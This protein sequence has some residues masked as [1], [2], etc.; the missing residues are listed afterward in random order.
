MLQFT[1]LIPAVLLT[2]AIA[3]LGAGCPVPG[4]LLI[5]DDDDDDAADD[6]DATGD[7]DTGDD[8]TGDDD[9]GDDDT[10]D[11]DTGD[12]DTGDDDTGDDD[13][14]PM[15]DCGPFALPNQMGELRAY[16]GEGALQIN[17]NWL[18]NGCEVERRF[19]D[20]QLD[21]EIL[22]E[23]NGEYYHWDE[24]SMTALYE[25]EFEV[26][27]D[28]STCPLEPDHHEQLWY[29]AA[30]FDWGDGQ[31][32]LAYSH[33]PWD[34]FQG[35]ATADISEQGATAPFSYRTDFFQ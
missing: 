20:G 15:V 7:D 10:G 31:M 34:D 16:A 27:E 32:H 23:V 21:C 6:D 18:W 17:Q 1:R 26:D 8:D 4:Q 9:T 24:S 30:E 12:D 11:D 2:S 5:I 29:Y 14:A 19:V 3:L 22:W 13:S 35:W 33:E 28:A 25:L